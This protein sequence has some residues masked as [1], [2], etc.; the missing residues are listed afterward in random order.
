MGLFAVTLP[1]LSHSPASF[2]ALPFGLAWFVSQPATF[3]DTLDISS[4]DKKILRNIARRTWLY[5]ATFVN[6]ENNHLPPDNFQEDPKPLIA[7]RTSPTNIGIYLLSTIAACDFGWISFEETLTRVECTLSTLAKMEKFRGH[8]YNWYATD[9]LAP[10]LP[11]YI[12]TVDSG[13][14][15]GHLLTLSSASSEWA[16]TSPVFLQSDRAGLF[17]VNNIFEETVKEI[18]DNHPIL[19]PLRQQIEEHIAHFYRSIRAFT[20]KSDSTTSHITN[21]LLKAREIARLINEL[22]QKI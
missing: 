10:L 15:A 3:Q 7:Q 19:H 6:A 8:L 12:S 16:K 5:Y 11:T 21:L 13:N 2:I 17:D 18:P 20:E 14:L 22:D 9:T 4:E 1:L